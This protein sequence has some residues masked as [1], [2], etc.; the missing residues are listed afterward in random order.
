MSTARVEKPPA[1]KIVLTYA[2]YGALPDDGRRYE[3]LEGEFYMTP[4]RFLGL[5]I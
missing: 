4:G 5:N 3:L 1:G 2:Q